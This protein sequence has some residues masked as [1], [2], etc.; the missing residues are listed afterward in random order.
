MQPCVLGP[1]TPNMAMKLLLEAFDPHAITTDDLKAQALHSALWL[2]HNFLDE[3]H[4]ISQELHTPTGSLLHA[5]MH[6]R[7]PDAWNSKYWWKRVGSHPIF[8][9]LAEQAK[10]LGY[11]QRGTSW[12][13]LQFVDDVEAARG[14]GNDR[15][16]L[17]EAVQHTELK[18]V[19]VGCVEL[20]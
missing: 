18:L 8:A 2:A 14:H 20:G 16:R 3:S 5:I 17:L 15:E 12:D 13:P 4:D 1:G 7:E 10:A 6:R 11:V 9:A 19:V